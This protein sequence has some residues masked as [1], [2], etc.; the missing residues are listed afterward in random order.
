MT[1][2]NIA[3]ELSYYMGVSKSNYHFD[4]KKH[5]PNMETVT[6]T[7]LDTSTMA[8]VLDDIYMTHI[9][10][11]SE[12]MT[13]EDPLVY[14]N[15]I[16]RQW[17]GARYH[18]VYF[19]HKDD[20]AIMIFDGYSADNKVNMMGVIDGNL[21][22]VANNTHFTSSADGFVLNIKN[23]DFHSILTHCKQLSIEFLFE[24]AKRNNV[25]NN[26]P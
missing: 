14:P 18:C 15:Y 1:L 17:L 25:M 23:I 2:P 13:A 5:Y 11:M 19:K 20:C 26:H 4:I 7:T 3:G 10:C 8:D 16:Y 12:H 9:D 24:I 6:S 22:V 21:H